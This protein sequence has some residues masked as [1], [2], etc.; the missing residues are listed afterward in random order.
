MESCPGDSISIDQQPEHD[1]NNHNT[2]VKY[3]EVDY[4]NETQTEREQFVTA[5]K[6]EIVD[7]FSD[8]DSFQEYA[9]GGAHTDTGVVDMQQD[10][11]TVK[12][13]K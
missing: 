10:T 2:V 6:L 8:D 3:E 4:H 1:D 9:F 13:R 12:R 5:P 7:V 11:A